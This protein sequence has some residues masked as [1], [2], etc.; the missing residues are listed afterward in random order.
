MAVDRQYDFILDK[1][2]VKELQIIF[3]DPKLD[4]SDEVLRNLGVK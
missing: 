4:K 2:E 3:A 1:K